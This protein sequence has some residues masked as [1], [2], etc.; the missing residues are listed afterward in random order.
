MSRRGGAW[1]RIG[2]WLG[3]GAT[4]AWLAAQTVLQI[5]QLLT[6]M[7][8]AL[9]VAIGLEPVVAWLTRHRLRRGVAVAAVVFGLLVFLAG[10][11]ALIVPPVTQEV[12]ALVKAVP[13]WLQ[14]LHDHNST[15]GKLED[16]YH[17][18][19]TV[20][21]KLTSGSATSVLG[22]VLGAGRIVLSAVTSLVVVVVVTLY[23]MVGFP[24]IKQFCFRFIAAS[25]REGVRTITDEILI[26][27]GRFLLGNVATS[28]IAGL[29]TWAWCWGL[30]VPYPA[31]LGIFV[32]FMDLIPIVGST[33]GGVVVSL[34]ALV[35]SLPVA[36]ATAG[37][38]VAFRLAEDYLIM[39]RAM[40]Y[41]VDVHP[42]V[43]VVGVL[44]GG[45][46]LG[47]IGALVAIPVAVAIG[48]V[49]EEYVFARAD[50]S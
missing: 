8:L 13:S 26:R 42:I 45:A 10:F 41:A 47:I 44:V 1:F 49:L 33:I 16:H 7:L 14:Q 48:I 18:V 11:V 31:A 43:T 40:K 24:V 32:A 46:L 25:R 4:V 12:D 29:A 23:L 35:V 39:P 28:A 9:F 5:S 21:Q 3:L 17:I 19:A 38:Y 15:L 30:G 34:V 6:L 20:K 37:F 22:G 2:F 27:T 36:G 50:A